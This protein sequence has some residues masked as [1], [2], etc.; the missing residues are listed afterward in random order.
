MNEFPSE[1]QQLFKGYGEFH[2]DVEPSKDFM[3]RLWAKI[4][5]RRSPWFAMQRMARLMVVTAM[6]AALLM[7]AVLIP[8]MESQKPAGFY[9]DVV[10]HDTLKADQEYAASVSLP[11]L[12]APHR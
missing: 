9:A 2:E 4:E 5:A 10:A 12:E 11:D 8:M 7:G 3:P 6:A 1:L